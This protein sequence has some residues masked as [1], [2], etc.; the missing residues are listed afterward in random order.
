MSSAPSRNRAKGY[1]A[2]RELVDYLKRKGWWALRIPTSAS[3]SVPLPDVLAIRGTEL[4]AFEVKYRNRGDGGRAVA[5]IDK[6][7]IK[8]LSDFLEPFDLYKRSAVIALRV[9]GKWVFKLATDANSPIT[10]SENEK[11]QWSP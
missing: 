7:Q 9:R 2:E 3:S 6:D 11:S 5:R 4:V 10:V 8:K 1:R